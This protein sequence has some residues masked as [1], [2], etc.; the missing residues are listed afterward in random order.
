ME[1][2]LKQLV[3]EVQ[4]FKGD[5]QGFKGDFQGFKGDFQGFKGD[6]QGFKDDLQGFKESWKE[7]SIIIS[8]M[9]SN[10]EGLS[11]AIHGTNKRLDGIEIKFGA[12]L[13]GIDAKLNDTNADL[14]SFRVETNTNFRIFDRHLKMV[15]GA[16][17]ETITRV[18]RIEQSR[19]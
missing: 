15:E 11:A 9:R 2:I 7:Q 10:M 18:E 4:G 14:N 12:R 5:F 1:A 13:D 17:D 16:L 6:L 3:N 8:A 19:R